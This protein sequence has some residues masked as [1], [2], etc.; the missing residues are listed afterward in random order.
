MPIR[1][2][3]KIYPKIY[4]KF[5]QSSVQKCSKIQANLNFEIFI[6]FLWFEV[7]LNFGTI[8]R[9]HLDRIEGGFLVL[10]FQVGICLT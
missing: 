4:P 6:K 3:R 10:Q 1:N 7:T 2:S 9:P 5:D 8:V